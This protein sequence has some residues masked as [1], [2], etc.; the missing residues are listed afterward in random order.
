MDN[1]SFQTSKSYHKK[2]NL[3]C[4]FF[5]KNIKM[6]KEG[7]KSIKLNPYSL[8]ILWL[9]YQHHKKF[10]RT[11]FI[12]YFI[13]FIMGNGKN[14]NKLFYVNLVHSIVNYVPLFNTPANKDF[15]IHKT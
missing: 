10:Y 6:R 1:P 13:S 9:M 15:V 7:L 12:F 11:L 2:I 5:E 3:P 4:W 8:E 14:E